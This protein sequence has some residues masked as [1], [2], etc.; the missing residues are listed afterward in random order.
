MHDQE[1]F[2]S[3]ILFQGEVDGEVE[4]SSAPGESGV[5]LEIY[6]RGGEG[7]FRVSGSTSGLNVVNQGI[8]SSYEHH[9][10]YLLHGSVIIN[11]AY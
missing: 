3:I 2:C 10:Q 6:W 9:G 8:M 7:L 1:K 5:T 4:I 11:D